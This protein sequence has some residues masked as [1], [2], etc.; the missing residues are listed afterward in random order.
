[1]DN[2]SKQDGC[3]NANLDLR[4]TDEVL[5]QEIQIVPENTKAWKGRQEAAQVIQ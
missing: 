2:K 3:D 5:L 1:M 4:D